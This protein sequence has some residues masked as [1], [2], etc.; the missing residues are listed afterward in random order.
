MLEV[1][2]VGTGDAFCSGGRR[3]SGILL[4]DAGALLLL[5]CG[6]TTL[7]GLHGVGVD[8]L[9]IDAVAI[10]HFH[11]DHAAGLPFLLLAYRFGRP[12]TRPLEILGPPGIE[13]FCTELSSR[14]HYA[15]AAPPAYTLRYRTFEPGRALEIPGFRVAPFPAV[16]APETRPHMLRVEGPDRSVFFTGDTGWHEALPERVGGVDLLI[17]ECTQLE[18][19]DPHHLSYARLARERRRFTCGRMLLTH[20]GQEVLDARDD[21]ELALAEDGAVVSCGAA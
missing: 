14:L 9:E 19:R 15:S 11:G 13:A 21:L 6:P 7:Q 3:N 10:S 5:D 4:R 20:L 8:P 12:R 16:H 1:T 17:S 2:F 18:E